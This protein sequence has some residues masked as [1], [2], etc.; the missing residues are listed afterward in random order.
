MSLIVSVYVPTGIVLSGDSRTTG[1]TSQQ[2]ANPQNPGTQVTVQT[3]VV[4][5][6]AAEKI[7]LVDERCGVGT[8]GAA[9]IGNLPIAH[10]VEQFVQQP[11]RAAA[12]NPA[13]L[14]QAILQF[15]RSMTPVPQ[16]YFV[17]IG[18]DGTAPWVGVIDV[19][20][21]AVQ[22]KN[23]DAQGATIYGA[24]WGGDVA[25]ASRLLSQPQHQ[26]PFA[27]MNLQ[28]AIDFSRHLIRSTIDQMRFEPRFPSV[29]GP[30]DTL[31][32]SPTGARFLERKSLR[33]M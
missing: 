23:V 1:T 6:D 16:S 13:T 4:L 24:Q 32:V 12:A 27:V 7:F 28:D 33:C 20:N 14:A 30:V 18:Y 9:L 10:Y 8:Y 3:N 17:V 2:V 5:S 22:R 31:V 26:P 29:G 21:N 25:V 11:G 15:F 19:P